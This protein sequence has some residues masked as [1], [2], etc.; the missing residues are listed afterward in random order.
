LSGI[1]PV[2]RAVTLFLLCFF[3][4]APA[5]HP[6]GKSAAPAEPR[7][8][9]W[10][11][12]VTAFD[13]SALPP[14]RKAVGDLLAKSLIAGLGA[15]SYR[16]RSSAEYAY[17]TDYAW[18][19][20]RAA[21]AKALAEK[22]AK[23]DELVFQGHPE[24]KYLKELRAIEKEIEKLE[25]DLKAVSDTPP[26]VESEPAFSLAETN[27]AGG[28]PE[29]PAAGGEY[30][31]CVN[32]KADGFL[33]GSVIEYYGRLY[34]GVKLYTRY[35][36]SFQYEDAVI[37]SIEDTRQGI[38]ELT[39]R[40]T[41]AVSASTPASIA[42]RGEPADAVI[43]IDGAFAGTGEAGPAAHPPGVVEVESFAPDRQSAR[44]EVE[45]RPGELA[46]L[47]INLPPLGDGELT[48]TVPEG[49]ARVYQ[50]ALYLGNTP[51]Q[52]RSTG[53]RAAFFHIE[54]PDGKAASAITGGADTAVRLT[55]VFPPEG[56]VMKTRRQFYGS[57]ARF[58]VALP[59]AFL[60]QGISDAQVRAY[61]TSGNANLYQ[62]AQTGQ[63]I[64]V[65]AWV[66]FGL[67]TAEVLYRAGVYI[68]SSW[69]DVDPFTAAPQP[70]AIP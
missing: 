53:D 52:V 21:A 23:R 27:K 50:G 43:L 62:G 26:P 28:F 6:R 61:N 69:K 24:W 66:I 9:E 31:F 16:M 20:D 58:W 48:V 4:L 30:R 56:R 3:G 35:T 33:T 13:V 47:Y 12:A 49:E 11:L 17:Y 45:L 22:R 60:F 18:S 37:F 15:V 8:A 68:Y 63:I 44:Y 55:P 65:G 5:L 40:V 34:A 19:K 42:V 39:A 70:P 10:V 25:L 38:E 2:R 41:A 46:E 51:L 32:Q 59:T 54:T 67:V 7:S 57:W 29:A 1:T 14:A 64:S 36:K